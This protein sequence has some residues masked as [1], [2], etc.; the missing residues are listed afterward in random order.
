MVVMGR[1]AGAHGVRGWVKVQ[2]FTQQSDG[3]L[4]FR[5]WWLGRDGDWRP[6]QVEEAAVHGRSIIAKLAGCED[7]EGAAALRGAEVALP[8]EQLPASEAGEYYWSDLQGVQVRNLD[9]STLGVVTGL[10]ETGANQVLVVQAERERLIPFVEAVVKS[11]DLAQGSIV[12]DWGV[13]F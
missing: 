1:M 10:L 9:G 4:P 5:T 12:V 11:V 13:D 2:V 3:L 6:F 8:R 7:R